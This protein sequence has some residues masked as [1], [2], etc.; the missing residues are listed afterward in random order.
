MLVVTSKHTYCVSYFASRDRSREIGDSQL[1]DHKG[2]CW[3]PIS[4]RRLCV[5]FSL[6]FPA[7]RARIAARRLGNS[8]ECS[9]GKPQEVAARSKESPSFLHSI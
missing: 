6:V 4:L 5:S 8:A 7:A 2:F 9:S 3:L 1:L